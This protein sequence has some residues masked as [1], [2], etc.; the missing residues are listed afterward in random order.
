MSVALLDL[1]EKALLV[2][3]QA[4]GNHAGKPESGGLPR[5]AHIVA[6]CIRKEEEHT[7]S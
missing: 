7:F 2:A 4:L 6:H 3:K 1:V 5:E